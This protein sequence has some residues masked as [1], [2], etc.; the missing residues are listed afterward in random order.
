MNTFF[1]LFYLMTLEAID[2]TYIRTV[3]NLL[4]IETN[5]AIRTFE[6]TMDGMFIRA[7]VDE[8]LNRLAVLLHREFRVAVAD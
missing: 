5:V 4:S 2:P 1:V 8:Q 3:R 6:L 7:F